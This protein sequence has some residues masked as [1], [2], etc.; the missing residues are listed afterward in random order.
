[1]PQAHTPEAP[2]R[3]RPFASYLR[4]IDATPLLAAEEERELARRV[5]GG[6]PEARDHLV[7]ANL[8]L[9]VNVACKYAGKGLDVE[10]LVAE[11]NMGLLRAAEAFDH[12][13]GVRF[14]TYAIFWIKQSIRRAIVNTGKT[15][16]LPAYMAEL[17]VKWRRATA[18][19]HEELDRPP[20]HEEVG[21]HLNLSARRLKVI[22]KAIRIH[23]RAS[24]AGPGDEPL[25]LE[26]LVR[27]VS[28]GPDA[29][30]SSAEELRQVLGLLDRLDK[31]EAAVLRLRFGLGGEGPL[32]LR[33]IGAR[34]DLTRERVRQI[35]GDSLRK[36]RE[37]LAAA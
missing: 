1:M 13:R 31:R 22:Q 27:D 12:S 9:V 33:E 34:L 36:L 17:L 3:G 23:N 16:R 19:L 26:E 6:D 2:A 11:G 4:A 5:A 21:R 35:E 20:T 24:Q 8:R 18:Q 15:I 14:S 32:T 30:L 28:A 10:D 7:R 29:H 25:P 37:H